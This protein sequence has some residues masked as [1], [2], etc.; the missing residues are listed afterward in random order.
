MLG[1]SLQMAV[2]REYGFRTYLNQ[3]V[4]SELQYY[5]K[6]LTNDVS[7]IEDLCEDQYPWES[8]ARPLQDIGS[9]LDWTRGRMIF[10]IEGVRLMGHNINDK[11]RWNEILNKHE[12][13][14]RKALQ[15]KDKFN[16]HADKT[17]RDITNLHVDKL[18]RKGQKPPRKFVYIGV[19][20]RRHDATLHMIKK[21][22][23][24]E[25]KP[26]YYLD[27]MAMYTTYFKSN[28]KVV[29]L[30]T[31]D[32]VQWVKSRILPRAKNAYLVGSGNIFNMDSI[33]NDLAIMAR[34]NH[35]ILSY[36]TFSFWSGFLAGGKRI[37]PVILTMANTQ[38]FLENDF[39]PFRL[40]DEGVPYSD[41]TF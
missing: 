5:L 2:K 9:D 23:L 8:Y 7:S 37:T 21:F 27:A 36:G 17:I 41:D 22:S 35:T 32:D 31:S 40:P 12:G 38:S 20:I 3:T 19:H 33:G 1:Y 28:K 4:L 24:I 25:L 29:F 6:S 34:C 30:I 14:I 16:S 15:L 26:S 11:L 13:E 39:D 10:Y 18:R